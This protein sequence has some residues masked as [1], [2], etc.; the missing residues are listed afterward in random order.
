MG[1]TEISEYVIV[2]DVKG[3]G[4]WTRKALGEGMD[5][6]T[7]VNKGLIPGMD[8]VGE[9][10]KNFEY[11]LP[12]MLIS[13]RVMKAAM[14]LINPLLAGLEGVN[15]GKAVI[16]TVQGDIHDIGKNLVGMMLGGA[17]FEVIDLGTDVAADAYLKAVEES[18]AQL[19]CLSAL[20]TT[21]M[22]EMGTVIKLLD[23]AGIKQNVKT[24]VGGAPVT[25]RFAS[26]IGADG[27]A[28]DAGSAVD[29][30]KT[31]LSIAAS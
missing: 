26:E 12:E 3:A 2:G 23:D 28:T 14:A 8:V 11:Y 10:F 17:G 21:T 27:F 25:Q 16:G 31:L 7:I 1:V 13:A 9:K 22:T 5:A 19:L 24:M 6:L 15:V 29:E 4:E 18:G 20:L 30:A